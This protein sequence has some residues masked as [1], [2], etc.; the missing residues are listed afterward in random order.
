MIKKIIKFVLMSLKVKN[1]G[2]VKAI[3]DGVNPPLNKKL[4]WYYTGNVPYLTGPA[5]VHYYFN[6]VT[7]Q[8][9]PLATVLNSPQ[10]SSQNIVIPELE[11]IIKNPPENFNV[12]KTPIIGAIWLP[13]AQP[14]NFSFLNLNP[15]IWL[16][17]YKKKSHIKSI[18]NPNAPSI[19]KRRNGRKWAHP[20]H[21]NGINFP[22]GNMYSGENRNLANEIQP[23]KN[24][25]FNCSNEPYKIQILNFNIEDWVVKNTNFPFSSTTINLPNIIKVLGDRDRKRSAIFKFAI[26]CDNP[27]N[28]SPNKKIIGPMSEQIILAPVYKGQNSNKS[29]INYQL[30]TKGNI[31][32]R[33]Y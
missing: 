2:L 7:N 30:K 16:F 4:I 19:L 10:I 13:V 5:K 8:W 20:S 21:Q 33:K 11:I 24:T 18:F 29:F 15:Q 12:F 27:D 25:E 1:L 22:N 31:G 3:H 6:V 17:R 23:G 32:K 26:V 14:S 9:E 28:S